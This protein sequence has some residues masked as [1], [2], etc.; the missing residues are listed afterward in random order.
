MT[1][2]PETRTPAE[3][4][5]RMKLVHVVSGEDRP[6]Y[7]FPQT[8]K[9]PKSLTLRQ[10]LTGRHDVISAVLDELLHVTRGTNDSPADARSVQITK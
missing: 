9:R 7:Q 10:L 2:V 3:Q 5:Q 1:S 8:G 4:Y 6:D